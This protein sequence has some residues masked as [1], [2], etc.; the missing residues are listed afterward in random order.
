MARI[1]P[2]RALRP[3]QDKAEQVSCVPYDVVGNTEA[4]AFVQ[5][6][7]LSFLRVTRSEADFSDM[8]R[9]TQ[10][11][12][13]VRARSNL[14]ELINSGALIKEESPAFYVY[15]LETGSHRQTGLVACVSLDE[16]EKGL[17]KK[18]ENVRP[19]KVKERTEHM[20]TL[21]AQ[22]GLIFLAYRDTPQTL[23][24]IHAGTQSDPL[25]DFGCRE[26]IRHTIW[27]LEPTD[28][29]IDAF[30]DVP[31]LYIADGHH[32]IESARQ[33]RRVLAA[34]SSD[35][36]ADLNYVM[37]GIFPSSELKILAYNRAVHDLNGLSPEQFMERLKPGFVLE[38][39][40]E[41]EPHKHGEI[42]MYLAGRWYKLRFN[43]QYVREPDVI[44]RLDVSILQDHILGPILGIDDPTT[45]ERIEFIGGRS[46][47]N[48]LEALVDSGSAMVA[49][50][51]F[52]T[53]M[54]DLLEVSDQNEV[55]PPKSTWFEPKLK[56]GLLIHLI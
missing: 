1:K 48:D 37:A 13:F 15:R 24:L 42:C 39:G 26:D 6:N 35:P 11:Q 23:V 17:I 34:G 20:A 14:D 8:E 27:K 31:S 33:A 19:D 38:E 55:M 30:A 5:A 44:E 7:P 18:H 50:S 36:D 21:R 47:P 16:Y 32:R 25:Y 52:P 53:T 56:D 9:P 40:N 3:V 28:E 45:N 4:R 54:E 46:G 10:E 22:T 43:V 29:L 2:F 41:R 51:L 49:F 12:T